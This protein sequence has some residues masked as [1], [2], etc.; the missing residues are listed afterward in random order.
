MKMKKKLRC[1]GTKQQIL[2]YVV[3]S[4]SPISLENERWCVYNRKKEE[5]IS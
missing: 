1:F 2:S 5:E 4:G 3:M